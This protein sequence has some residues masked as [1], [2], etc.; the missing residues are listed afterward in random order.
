MSLL[1]FKIINRFLYKD[2]WSIGFIEADIR[3]LEFV[4]PTPNLL[5]IPVPWGCYVADPFI[6]R[7]SGNIF[8]FYERYDYI[9]RIGK[10]VCA[11]LSE[12]LKFIEEKEMSC[13]C[14]HASYPFILFYE[15]D[16]LLIPE[17]ID[18]KKGPIYNIKI[19]NNEPYLS[20][21]SY[22][23]PFIGEDPTIYFHNDRFWLWTTLKSDSL[24]LFYTS[25]LSSEWIPH[26]CNPVRISK[27]ARPAGSLFSIDGRLYR[28]SQDCTNSYG[29]KI[30]INEILIIDESS[31]VEREIKTIE[32]SAWGGHGVHT[33]NRFEK[34]LIIDIN[35]KKIMIAYILGL[36][37]KMCRDSFYAIQ[38][39]F[40]E[41]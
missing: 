20:L 11:R 27:K 22:K 29:E 19:Y 34:Y 10:V 28:P 14:G 26:K 17:N 37:I 25:D 18:S 4:L 7:I 41:R 16:T 5:D 39:I 3:D 38:K 24:Y 35:Y 31:Y 2:S 30:I 36:V 9:R 12:D 40:S 15:N 6:A 13:I 23:L 33:V 8:L 1:N 21:A 32:S